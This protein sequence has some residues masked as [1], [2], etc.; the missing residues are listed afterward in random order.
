M[1]KPFVLLFFLLMI[2]RLSAQDTLV[3]SQQNSSMFSNK[4]FLYPK[5]KT[6][7]H[8]FK[9]DDGQLWYGKGT[10]KIN[11]GKLFLSFGD[12]EKDIKKENRIVKI[13]DQT[14]KTDTLIVKFIDKKQNPSSGHIKFKEEYFYSD[15]DSG[16]VKI[17]KNRFKKIDNPIVETFIQG[18]L[19]NIELTKLSELKFLKITAYDIYSYYH[20]ESNFER[21][22]KFQNDK[23]ISADFYNTVNKRKVKFVAEN[24]KG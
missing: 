15:F 13:Y 24:N 4:Y 21:V 23:I 22:L 9:T 1:E 8:K 6:F 18:S 3:F 17:P 20:F 14:K 12:S 19:I 16:T 2:M 10:Y 5:S 7:E 11:K